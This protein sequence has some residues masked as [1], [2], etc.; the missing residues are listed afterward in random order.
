MARCVRCHDETFTGGEPMLPA[1]DQRSLALPSE[2]LREH[3]RLHA[4]PAIGACS[5]GASVRQQ[6]VLGGSLIG[7]RSTSRQATHDPARMP[8]PPRRRAERLGVGRSHSVG[9]QP[10]CQRHRRCRSLSRR[11]AS[12]RKPGSR[13]PV[14][15]A[16]A[17][18][19]DPGSRRF[20]RCRRTRPTC[21]RSSRPAASR[22]HGASGMLNHALNRGR[23]AVGCRAA[24][25]PATCRTTKTRA[26]AATRGSP[27]ARASAAR[28]TAPRRPAILPEPH[29]GV[30]SSLLSQ[31][32]GGMPPPA[33]A[34][35]ERRGTRK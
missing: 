9:D 1:T 5:F 32:E 8:P 22:C 10:R 35:G 15:F 13:W 7:P 26:T 29:R 31:A 19:D 3:G 34:R 18:C 21:S 4:P 17:A 33:R 2:S 6:P 27:R 23:N 12:C 20:P 14:A 28:T 24:W 30:S 11:R 25:R 16:L